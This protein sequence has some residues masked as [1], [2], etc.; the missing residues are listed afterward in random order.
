MA[1]AKIITAVTPSIQPIMQLRAR[2][3]L[4]HIVYKMLYGYRHETQFHSTETLDGGTN[5]EPPS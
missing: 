5:A 2:L 3:L 1:S 4:F